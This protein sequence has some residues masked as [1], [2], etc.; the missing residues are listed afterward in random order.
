MNP[1]LITCSW[2]GHFLFMTYS[3]LIH[4]FFM[5][6]P[7]PVHNFFMTCL[8]FL[9]SGNEL[10]NPKCLS[11]CPSKKSKIMIYRLF[12]TLNTAI[13]K[14][15]WTMPHSDFLAWLISAKFQIFTSGVST[16]ILMLWKA[17]LVYTLSR[18]RRRPKNEDNIK[19]KM[20]SKI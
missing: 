17:N 15:G 18:L 19:M 14:L 11:V 5:T 16:Q 9:T 6:L 4:S 20:T 13:Q 7:W 3:W 1:S 12:R 2:L 8:Q 10:Q